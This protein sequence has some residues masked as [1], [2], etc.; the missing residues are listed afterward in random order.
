MKKTKSLIPFMTFALTFACVLSCDDQDE[1]GVAKNNITSDAISSGRMDSGVDG[2]VGDPVSL[3]TA[4]HWAA[5]Y[6][7]GNPDGTLGHYFGFEIIQQ[8]LNQADCV[9]IRI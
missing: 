7:E 6:R 5:N 8:I 4:Q 2:T 3:A 9:G 1:K